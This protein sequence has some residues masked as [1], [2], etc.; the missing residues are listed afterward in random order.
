MFELTVLFCV[1]LVGVAIGYGY[2]AI[3]NIGREVEIADEAYT[4][5]WNACLLE[6]GFVRP[7]ALYDYHTDQKTR[8]VIEDKQST[9]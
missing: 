3:S 2:K 6:N 7:E 5:G 8:R 1:T 4:D 9:L